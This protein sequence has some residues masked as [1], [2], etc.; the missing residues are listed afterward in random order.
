MIA[1]SSTRASSRSWRTDFTGAA[2]AWVQARIYVLSAFIVTTAI[3]DRLEPPPAFSPVNDGLFAWDGTWYRSIADNGYQD[4]ADPALRFFP[5]WPLLARFG[6][7]LSAGSTDVAMIVLANGAALVAAVLFHRLVRQET[8]DIVLARRAA[9]L[10]SLVPPA[11]VLVLA[12]SE[13]LYLALAISTI[14]MARRHRWLPTA[15]LAFAAGLTRPVG[16]LLLLPVAVSAWRDRGHQPWTRIAAVTAAPLGS[17]AYLA[18]AE[19]AIGDWTAPID[20]QKDLRGGFR[21]P[22]SRL[23]VATG[24]AIDGDAGEFFHLCAAVLLIALTVVVVRRLST[25]LAVYTVPTV[26][27]LISAQNLNSMERYALAAFPLVIAAAIVSRHRFVDKW[28]STASAVGLASLC[29]L[30]LNGVYVP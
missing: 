14:M 16:G 23:V 29:M 17:I 12:Y 1:S 5:L 21:E 25:D 7:W 2:P 28:V 10:F 27:I 24:R 22:I 9:T 15:G 19:I 4:A 18:W 8:G 30:A 11:F 13:P 20:R 6:S 3:I 26:L